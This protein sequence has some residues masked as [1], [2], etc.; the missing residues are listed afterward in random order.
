[1]APLTGVNERSRKRRPLSFV[2]MLEEDVGR[3]PALPVDPSSPVD[4]CL[5][6]VLRSAK[7]H[8]PPIARIDDQTIHIRDLVGIGGA[9]SNVPRAEHVVGFFVEPRLVPELER[10]PGPLR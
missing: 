8:I 3:R 9:E 5:I 6:G 2:F 1:M 7:A 4:K 10:A